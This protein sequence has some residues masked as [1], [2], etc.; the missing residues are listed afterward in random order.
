MS[1][2]GALDSKNPAASCPVEG[3]CSLK[4]LCKCMRSLGLK[5]PQR[6]SLSKY[7]LLYRNVTAMDN[8]YVLLDGLW[9]VMTNDSEGNVTSW[10]VFGKGSTIGESEYFLPNID[11]YIVQALTGCTVCKFSSRDLGELDFDDPLILREI[12]RASTL[13]QGVFCK[14]VW[15]MHPVQLSE[16]IN[17]LFLA[18]YP[19]GSK[20]GGYVSLGLS[21]SDIAG[22]VNA[23]RSAVT[24]AM[25]KLSDDGRLVLGYGKVMLNPAYFDI[26][27]D[28][29]R[30]PYPTWRHV[31]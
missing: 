23:E 1:A 5:S 12:I 9:A 8:I 18:L 25:K 29:S 20:E 16:R 26:I 17:R 21:H 15:I 31:S 7:D 28:P 6:I 13:N 11:N 27:E 19:Y 30:Y 2:T 14:H 3:D 4:T 22:L 10:G 24:H